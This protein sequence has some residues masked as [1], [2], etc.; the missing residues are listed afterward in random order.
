MT[1]LKFDT[2][3]AL[4]TAAVAASFISANPLFLNGA[5]MGGV[6]NAAQTVHRDVDASKAAGTNAKATHVATNSKAAANIADDDM[7]GDNALDNTDRH[8]EST[9]CNGHA[10]K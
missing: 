3:K 10:C 8:N 4:L 6:A 1:I 5:L 7:D 9:Y 2:R